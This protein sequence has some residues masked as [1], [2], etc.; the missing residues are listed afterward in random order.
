MCSCAVSKRV[1]GLDCSVTEW[2][3]AAFDADVG[4]VLGEGIELV[5]PPV[6]SF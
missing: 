2:L 1:E 4:V 5:K 6:D 3:D